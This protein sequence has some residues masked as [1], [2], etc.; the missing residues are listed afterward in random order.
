MNP[1]GVTLVTGASGEIGTA[2]VR[3]L[4]GTPGQQVLTSDIRP[5]PPG[6]PSPLEHIQG[7]ILERD[8]W[9]RALAHRP[10]RIVHLAALLSTRTESAPVPAHRVN[11]EGS[12]RALEAAVA[13]AAAGPVQFLFPSSIAVYGLPSRSAKD[14]AAPVGEDDFLRPITLYGAQKLYIEHFGAVL[15]REHPNL[16]FR[17]VRF[18]GL[19]SADTL[20]SGGTSDWAPE[21]IHAAA[22]G[23]P[24]TC[25]VR[26]DA[27]LPFC[28]MPTAVE[29]LARLFAADKA[30][31]SRTAYNFGG[32]S[33]SAE[34]VAR[35]VRRDF[36]G[37]ERHFEPDPD[38]DRIVASWPAAVDDGA[39]RRDFGWRPDREAEALFSEYLIP[40]IRRRY[41]PGRQP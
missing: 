13:L 22:C 15:E 16:D 1:P 17:A 2:L 11:V 29:G 12:V 27:R 34:E 4:A 38:R 36:P 30:R 23:E 5:L 10:H 7:D 33:L 35:R 37:L 25:F 20:P 31:L 41:P 9:K 32:P 28:A 3:R 8:V 24:F 6:L 21:M 14:A 39:A 18:P 19:L 26:P 40:N